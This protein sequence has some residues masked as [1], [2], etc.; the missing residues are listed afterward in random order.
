LTSLFIGWHTVLYP[1][2]HLCPESAHLYE[3]AEQHKKW[4]TVVSEEQW[5]QFNALSPSVLSV[6]DG[7]INFT[8]NLKS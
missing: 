7:N 2:I 4:E 5:P 3:E 1:T 6:L 8:P